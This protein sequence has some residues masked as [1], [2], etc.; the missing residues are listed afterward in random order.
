[1]SFAEACTELNINSNYSDA[2]R[3]ASKTY[4][5][6]TPPPI[7]WQKTAMNFCE[8]AAKFLWTT[9]PA[10]IRARDYLMTE[11]CLTEQIIR[12]KKLGY[13]PLMPGGKWY[14]HD[15]LQ[16]GFEHWGLKDTD[17]DSPT[18]R[19]RGTILIPPGIVIPWTHQD[20]LW[21][22]EIKRFEDP[23][24]GHRFGQIAGS[25]NG[26]YNA[27]TM[28]YDVP[29]FMVESSLCALSIEQEA[30]DIATAIAT[31]GTSGGRNRRFFQRYFPCQ[32]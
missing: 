4:D 12:E 30:S 14:G 17:V 9:H 31:G 20:I 11:R 19:E 3:P 25:K 15:P 7:A 1:M 5:D 2:Q 18:V 23:G 13:C 16:G 8:R 28:R 24:N 29:V 27:D 32:T 22:V 26:L 21:K 10:A 6:N